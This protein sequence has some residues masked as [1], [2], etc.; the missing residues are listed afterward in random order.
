[1]SPAPHQS[2]P[3]LREEFFDPERDVW[4]VDTYTQHILEEH[5]DLASY[6][7]LAVTGGESLKS[8]ETLQTIVEQLLEWGV[9]RHS[10]LIAV[11]GGTVG[12]VV[13]FAASIIKR[14]IPWVFVPTTL[15]AQVDSS[16]G[17]KTAINSAHGKNLIG[18]FHAPQ[19]LIV[20]TDWLHT[21]TLQQWRCGFAELLKIAYIMDAT[22]WQEIQEC[23]RTHALPTLLRPQWIDR[24][25]HYKQQIVARDFREKTTGCRQWLNLGHT[26][27]HMLEEVLQYRIHHGE[28][29]ALGW[30]LEAFLSESLHNTP[31][32]H[33]RMLQEYFQSLGYPLPELRV[34]HTIDP[35]ILLRVLLQ[36][37]KNQARETIRFILPICPGQVQIQDLP[38]SRVEAYIKNLKDK[39]FR[40]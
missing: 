3:A 38:R 1:M 18:S 40:L 17:G 19:R 16:I 20:D 33:G 30:V 37:K 35:D 31:A 4:I 25:I 7:V 23:A 15:L 22:W 28:A 26:F 11:G 34:L 6:Q 39:D 9:T 2:F 27:G 29:V 36:D 8:W 14:G 32:G 13:G 12:D 10:R 5:I 21:L 24:A